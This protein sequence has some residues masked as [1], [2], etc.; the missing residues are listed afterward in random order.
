MTVEPKRL[1]AALV[2]CTLAGL[3]RAEPE[4]VVN[5]YTTSAQE[6]PRLAVDGA[7]RFVVVWESY[8]QDGSLDGIFGQRLSTSGLPLGSEFQVN[9]DTTGN[10]S[11]PDV[12]A[13]AAGNFIVVWTD[14]DADGSG[15]VGR[16]YNSSGAPVGGEFQ[17]NSYTTN[18][19]SGASIA[20][21][22]GGDFVVMWT[23]QG[24]DGDSQ[25]VFARRFNSAGVP[26]GP[27]FQVNVGTTGQQVPAGVAADPAGN[28]VVAWFTDRNG[29]AYVLGRRYDSAGVPL[30]GEFQINTN[31]LEDVGS[32]GG[33][34][35]ADAAGNFV[36]VWTVGDFFD[37]DVVAR[38][39]DAAGAP[40]GGVFQ[41]NTFTNDGQLRP[42]V[43]MEPAGG[44]LIV[45]SIFDDSPAQE[46]EGQRYDA[47]GTP[48]GSEFQVN[49]YT[50]NGKIAGDVAFDGLG[51]FM[52]T[53]TSSSQDGDAAGILARRNKPE[54]QVRG[55]KMRLRDPVNKEIRRSIH[56]LGL[57]SETEIGRVLDG[58]PTADG[59][60]LR[61]IINGANP[62]DQTFVLDASGWR[63]PGP[64]NFT[65]KGPTGAD[66]DPVG[67]LSLRRSGTG[68]IRMKAVLNGGRGTQDL[69]VVPANPTSDGGIVV[70]FSNGGGTYCLGF[71]G[72]AGGTETQ[73]DVQGWRISGAVADGDC[74]AP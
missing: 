61:V 70:Q 59:A 8:G 48:M 10:Q 38:R 6:N 42:R 23:S 53:W 56:V 39:F 68:K 29:G 11:S 51:N 5:T 30:G 35:A 34:V 73:D 9:T 15:I 32:G 72:A 52:V 20:A 69:D 63:A 64:T 4:I 47:A 31:T 7:G 1:I 44:S 54:W 16:R 3:A 22:A 19:Q 28:F 74:P 50:T 21:A 57:E 46:V 65:Y 12:A 67:R 33:A 27:D 14:V 17:V 26:F 2:L 24:Q 55:K 36:V 41:A 58:N 60:T 43:A 71:G 45:W 66:G 13:D 49:T 37:A 25:G 40:L 18:A 62:S